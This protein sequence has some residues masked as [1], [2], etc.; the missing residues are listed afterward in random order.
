MIAR[1]RTHSGI[2]RSCESAAR[3]TATRAVLVI[4]A[5][6][7]ELIAPNARGAD[8]SSA[9]IRGSSVYSAAELFPVYRGQLG[10]PITV[11]GARAI[12]RALAAKYEADGYS[13]PQVRVDDALIAAGVLRVDVL[14]TRIDEV[15]IS[16]DPGPHRARLERLGAQLAGSAPV[17]QENMQTALRRMR[18][19]PGLTVA[20]STEAAADQVNVYRLDID[21]TFDALTGAVRLSNRGT[22]EVGPEFVLGQVVAN[23]LFRGQTNIGLLFGAALDYDEYRGLG[24]LANVGVGNAGGRIAA[25]G[26][27]SRSDPQEAI[28]DRD[29]SY[30]RD[31]VSLRYTR[32][33]AGLARANLSLFG[34]LD[35]DDLTIRRVNVSL[36]D[37]RLR[38]LETGAS[39]T[40]RG[41]AATQY[42]TTLELVKGLD[43]LGSGL[44]A[45]DLA[46][47]SRSVDFTLTR[48]TF[49]RLT[50]LS[51]RW[52]LRLD[53][54]A[55][56]SAYVLPYNERF[57]I[58]GD[59]LGRGF[60]VAEI[61]GDQGIGAKIEGRRRLAGVPAALG[62][63]S[64]Y[65]FYD[66]GAAWKQDFPGRESAATGGIGFATQGRRAS[67][68]I[69][70]AQPLT[71]ADVEGS[72]GLSIF[73]ELSITF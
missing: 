3:R 7:F 5:S 47:D 63:T 57:K 52:T 64:V 43:G 69:E 2:A 22:E 44:T 27:R 14:E 50:R 18:E 24:V 21:T 54:F 72:T 38:M 62:R 56:T 4:I 19:L 33:V 55:Q 6:L 71:H 1:R 9:V 26:F 13:R 46:T 73:A 65:A 53:G 8:L 45:L 67:G 12:V 48:M 49:V 66:L 23:G 51:E 16:G 25:T 15:T 30:L 31:R 70:L 41:G 36:R 37:E 40:W 11:E 39:A 32:P 58:G 17:R 29:D 20:A 34:G 68:M 60:E 42:A 61:A 10:K 28:V 35:L 59:R